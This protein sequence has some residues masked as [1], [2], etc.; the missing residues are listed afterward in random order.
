MNFIQTFSGVSA[1]VR[2]EAQSWTAMLDD[3]KAVCARA[4]G[5]ASDKVQAPAG[6]VAVLLT[7]DAEMQRLNRTWRGR[8]KPTDVLSFPAPDTIPHG[9]DRQLGDIALG[10]ETC[11][12]DAR[13]MKREM[14][15][16][17]SHLVVHGFLHLLGY[18]HEAPAEAEIMEQLEAQILHDLGWPDPYAVIEAGV[19]EHE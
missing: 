14:D 5:A 18:D 19:D 8:D 17:V 1:D 2:I 9:L 10:L 3:A 11:T 7:S 4:I 15:F 13:V 6:E 16:H 12:A